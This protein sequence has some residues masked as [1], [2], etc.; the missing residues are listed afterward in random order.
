MDSLVVQTAIGMVFVFATFAAVVSV[1][2]E[3]IARFI[4]LRGEYLLRGLSTLLDSPAHLE[5]RPRDVMRRRPGPGPSA[6]N[7][8]PPMVVQVM[9]HPLVRVSANKGAMPSNPGNRKL[10]RRERQQ[11]PSYLPARAFASAMIRVLVGD[12]MGKAT[13]VE[14]RQAVTALEKRPETR[15][16]AK[17]LTTFVDAS[18]NSVDRF[19]ESL[20]KWYDD[21]MA[22]VAGWYKRH[23]RWIS[24][25]IGAVLVLSINLSA[26]GI[27]RSL[28][29]DQ[30]LRDSVVT[31]ATNA[32]QCT[33]KDPATCLRAIRTQIDSM[34]GAGLPMG[35]RPVA[36]CVPHDK[37][38][39]MA[40]YGLADPTRSGRF[41]ILF[42]LLVV[43]GWTAMVLAL[44][45]GA[46]FWFDALARL[47]TLRS[48]GP[49]PAAS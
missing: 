35:W 43:V 14:I 31:E 27:A 39:W 21:H 5:L 15:D 42:F 32:A 18:G 17:M 13:I 25:G 24:L 20:E 49:K 11:L 1:V 10:S 22:R 8:P 46:R 40:R 45:P 47:G 37:C 6:G 9:T 2:T 16:L 30:A 38:S 41:D 12:G 29:T 26:V 7:A 48:T 34:Q 36:E 23:V 44:V 3:L 4:G 19:R 33:D 28:Y